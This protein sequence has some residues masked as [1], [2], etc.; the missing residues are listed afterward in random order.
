[1]NDVRVVRNKTN[2]IEIEIEESQSALEEVRVRA[3]RYE[4]SPRAPVSTYGFSREDISR[5]PE[6]QGDIFRAIG[7]LPGVSSSG[8]EHSAI[9]VRGQGVRDNIYMVDDIPVT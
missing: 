9:A 4:S 2:Y 1:I 7:M 3:F 5:N 8:V 6:A